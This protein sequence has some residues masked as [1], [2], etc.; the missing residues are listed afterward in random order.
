MQ[1]INHHP[2]ARLWIVTGLTGMVLLAGIL[3]DEGHAGPFSTPLNTEVMP[4]QKLTVEQSHKYSRISGKMLEKKSTPWD[5]KK[6]GIKQN[7]VR[8]Q[9]PG[10]KRLGLALFFLGALAG[11]S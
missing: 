1:Y 6:D 10:K 4:I 9:E 5:Q 2:T 7:S 3:L 8:K 11:K